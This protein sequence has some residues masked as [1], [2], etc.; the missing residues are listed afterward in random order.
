MHFDFWFKVTPP[1]CSLSAIGKKLL[2]ACKPECV[3][4]FTILSV[5]ITDPGILDAVVKSLIRIR[6]EINHPELEIV[7]GKLKALSPESFDNELIEITHSQKV[8]T[9][10]HRI[11]QERNEV[12]THRIRYIVKTEKHDTDHGQK[13]IMSFSLEP[14]A[15][16]LWGDL[17]GAL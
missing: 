3:H 1:E 2:Y 10:Y 17:M 13:P 4:P 7:L 12:K 11:S 16:V 14:A 9:R 5:G 6:R 15:N 8:F